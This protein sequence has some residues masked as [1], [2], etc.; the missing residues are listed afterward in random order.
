MIE[1]WN[2]DTKRGDKN[3]EE[4]LNS[5]GYEKICSLYLTSIYIDVN[6]EIYRA[7]S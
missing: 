6:N 2:K 7:L 3:I 1:D 5:K 4:I